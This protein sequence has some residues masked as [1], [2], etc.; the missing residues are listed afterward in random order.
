MRRRYRIR[1]NIIGYTYCRGFSKNTTLDHSLFF[2][3]PWHEDACP[4]LVVFPLWSTL[5]SRFLKWHTRDEEK[6]A[7]DDDPAYESEVGRWESN[8]RNPKP[9]YTF[10]EII[11]MTRIAIESCSE[12]LSWFLDPEEICELSICYSLEYESQEC[13]DSTNYEKNTLFCHSDPA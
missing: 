7:S 13:D 1:K 10:P 4:S 11:R 6:E 5:I 9:E 3:P 2:R 12:Y 8:E